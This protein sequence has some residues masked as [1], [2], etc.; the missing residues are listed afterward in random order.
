M[1]RTFRLL[2]LALLI[3]AAVAAQ[4]DYRNLDDD[5]PSAVEDAY[6]LE[7]RALELSLQWRT[8][9]AD[10]AWRH[11]VVPELAVGALPNLA[12]G[13]KVP[14][15]AGDRFGA[16]PGLA[17]L[18]LFSLYNFFTESPALPALSLRGDLHLPVGARAGDGARGSLRLLAT[19]STGA[20]RLHLN[21]GYGFGDPARPAAVEPLPRWSAGLALDRTFFRHSLLLVGD[22]AA[23]ATTRHDPTEVEAGL[24][25]RWQWTPTLV[26]D[27]GVRRRLTRH[28]ADLGLRLGLTQVLGLPGARR[29]A[30]P[31]SARGDSTAPGLERR[32]ERFYHPGGFN[33]AF[34]RS[35]PEAARLFHAFDY[36]HAVLYE[37]LLTSGGD[38]GAELEERQFAY[39]VTDLLRHPPRLGVPEETIAPAY[40]RAAW[41][42]KLMFDRAHVLHRQIYDIYADERLSDSSRAAL[43]ERVT[44]DYLADPRHAFTVMPK[45]M[46][47]MEDQ[48]YS[49][50]FRERYPRFNGLI[51]AY[52][53]LQ[54]GLYEPLVTGRT[55]EARRAGVDAA[56]RQFW[57]LLEAPP[58]RMPTVMPMTTAVAP[59]F[60]RRHPRAAA[61]FDNLHAMHDII[62]DILTSPRVP[63]SRKRAEIYAALA[64]YRD[65]SRDTMAP[66]HWW[67][68]GEMMGGVDLMGG[69]APRGD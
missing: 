69:P 36:G 23:L 24:G 47:L 17:G 60:S 32:D 2:G 37:R 11:A 45:G 54:V 3:P 14:L 42:A 52:H 64:R 63:A 4:A 66:E 62:S 57:T 43:V 65:G 44:D 68:M 15:A 30:P 13:L 12:V 31:A 38:A 18:R 61:I 16:D 28:G 5:R 53:W 56:L 50:A 19:R 39:L 29:A 25:L 27:G 49:R 46:E 8:A 1:T 35:F 20:W 40:A 51:W 21:G 9:R 58:S 10:G 6:P 34:L 55:P 26:L 22:A 48:Y 67:M 7:R 41:R 59:A 33:W